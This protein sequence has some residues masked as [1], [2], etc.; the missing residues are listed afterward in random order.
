MTMLQEH[1]ANTLSIFRVNLESVHEL[2]RFDSHVVDLTVH[3]LE[4]LQERL[5]AVHGADNSRLNVT[6]TLALVR[7]IRSNDSLQP[8]YQ[9]MLNQ[10]NVL[11]V[12]YFSSAVGDIFKA[13]LTDA[14]KT[15][16]RPDIM[17]EKITMDLEDLREIG[18]D[19]LDRSGD[20]FL[21]NHREINLQNM[22]STAKAFEDYFGYTRRADEVVNDITLSH[23]CRHVIVHCG[24]LVD[25]KMVRQLKSAHPRTLK[26][27]VAENELVQFSEQEIVVVGAQMDS[28]LND[29]VKAVVAD[30]DGKA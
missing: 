28:Y 10:C 14:V 29:L 22:Q 21:A 11:L 1:L 12:S 23:A 18:G 9:Q 26:P 5:V 7:N 8:H 17:K 13:G 19:V 30:G 25:W 16:R 6:N 20:L 24:A 4:S 15:G 27:H 2:M 3:L